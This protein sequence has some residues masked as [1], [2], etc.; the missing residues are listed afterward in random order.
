[1][2][3]TKTTLDAANAIDQYTLINEK[4][5]LS[6]M[7]LNYGGTL[8]H[9]LVPDKEGHI[10][11]VCV[12]FDDFET[13]KNPKN[14]YF[15]ALIGRFANRWVCIYAGFRAETNSWPLT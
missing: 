6:V 4:K 10:R 7:V 2:P 12:G 1:M 9:I 13:Y 5:T 14:P 8:T 3:V 15:G 11:D